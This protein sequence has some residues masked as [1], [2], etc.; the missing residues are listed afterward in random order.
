[1]KVAG[2]PHRSVLPTV[3][4][5]G[6]EGG[7]AGGSGSAEGARGQQKVKQGVPSSSAYPP[8][9]QDDPPVGEVGQACCVVQL[10]S[11]E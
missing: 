10:Q 9:D 1:M 8:F 2:V 11:H 3:T 5:D 4:G 7:G 6:V